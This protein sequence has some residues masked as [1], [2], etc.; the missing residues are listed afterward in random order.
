[1]GID[2][3]IR[4]VQEFLN[5]AK[6]ARAGGMNSPVASAKPAL[7]DNSL[8]DA[9]AA[10]SYLGLSLS[11]VYKAAERGELPCVRIGAALRFD[12]QALV[13][14]VRSRASGTTK[15]RSI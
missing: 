15:L 8:M 13:E 6:N 5:E 4:T 12:R 14:W 1:M 7:P 3:A 11:W 10:A 2:S 9:R